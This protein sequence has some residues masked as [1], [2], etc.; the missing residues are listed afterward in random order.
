MT[1]RLLDQRMIAALSPRAAAALQLARKFDPSV[2]PAAAWLQAATNPAASPERLAQSLRAQ[3]RRDRRLGGAHGPASAIGLTCGY[4]EDLD[5]PTAD[6]AAAPDLEDTP[7]RAVA[8]M[9][10][11]ASTRD[12]ARKLDVTPRRVQQL[13][14]R[15]LFALAHG[16]LVLNLEGG[17]V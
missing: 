6:E 3:A 4:G 5:A 1:S 11:H 2:D 12:L 15:A 8:R 17:G 9:L 14:E 10:V 7:E 16:Q 13:K